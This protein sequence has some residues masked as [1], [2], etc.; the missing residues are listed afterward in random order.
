MMTQKEYEK[1]MA[2]LQFMAT[3]N[4]DSGALQA[5]LPVLNHY[6]TTTIE[7]F[8]RS[9]LD[10]RKNA[11]LLKAMALTT[12][13]ALSD[14]YITFMHRLD[15]V[16]NKGTNV[17]ISYLQLM[18]NNIVIDM[19]KRYN[20]KMRKND[21]TVTE[22]FWMYITDGNY[23]LEDVV[24]IDAECIKKATTAFNRAV[25]F[26][27]INA[28]AFLGLT[29][30][31]IPATLLAD[32]VNKKGIDYMY[33]YVVKSVA[34]EF[35]TFPVSLFDEKCKQEITSKDKEKD[36]T[37]K[38]LLNYNSYCCKILRNEIDGTYKK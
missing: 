29:V 30:M 8:L 7:P 32:A 31:D 23:S 21:V 16:M 19:F 24:D 35:K 25:N 26:K 15:T 20:A 28:I 18:I 2:M 5:D 12:D 36:I 13:S 33:E 10:T 3:H 38:M 34:R 27:K 11:N 4:Y 22:Q 14:V 37:A 6:A 9:A 17:T 1:M